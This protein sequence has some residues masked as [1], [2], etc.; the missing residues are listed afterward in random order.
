MEL[1]LFLT[2]NATPANAK[3][4]CDKLK[5][6]LDEQRV[7]RFEKTNAFIRSDYDLGVIVFNTN[8]VF[9]GNWHIKYKLSSDQK[10]EP[11][12]IQQFTPT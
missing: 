5:E 8:K 11:I 12:V 7:M 6:A 3:V 9:S 1:N 2:S 10:E 4:Y